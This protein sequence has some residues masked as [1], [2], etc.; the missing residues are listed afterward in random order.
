MK[1]TYVD[2]IS[3]YINLI[4]ITEIVSISF[5]YNYYTDLELLHVIRLNYMFNNN[6]YLC[7]Y[8]SRFPF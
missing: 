7:Q 2:L 3:I 8:T 5:N 1:I 6:V 4:S